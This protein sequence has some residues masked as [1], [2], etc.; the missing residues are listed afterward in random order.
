M[1][2]H[3]WKRHAPSSSAVMHDVMFVGA[4]TGGG[5]AQRSGDT[6]AGRAAPV[7]TAGAGWEAA[8][9]GSPPSPSLPRAFS[10]GCFLRL[11]EKNPIARDVR[12]GARSGAS[13]GAWCSRRTG[14]LRDC[15]FEFPPKSNC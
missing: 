6:R 9:T 7:V 11:G 12:D 1:C 8:G 14:G 13:P 2:V 15:D 5:A 4:T 10:A 3:G